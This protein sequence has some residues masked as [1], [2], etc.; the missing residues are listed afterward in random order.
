MRILKVRVQNINS[1]KGNWSVN[2][3][4]PAYSAGGLF[5]ICGPTGAGKSSLLDAIC[6]ALYGSTP[7][8]GELSVNA[9]EAMTRG[10][11]LLES[12]VTFLAKGERYRAL[13]SQRRARNKADGKLQ[14]ATIE[15]CRWNELEAKWEILEAKYKKRFTGLI[16][17]ITGL[18]FEQF[19]RSALLAQ[20]NFSVF[21]KAKDDERSN[22]LEAITGTEIYS[23]ISQAVYN[24]YKGE[25]DKLSAL[26]TAADTANILS[27]DARQELQRKLTNTLNRITQSNLTLS[28]KQ[29]L[30]EK[31]RLIDL[32][33]QTLVKTQKE[34]A[35]V[36][37]NLEELRNERLATDLARR[38]LRIKPQ[39]AAFIQAQ[40]RVA[41]FNQRCAELTATATSARTNFEKINREYLDAKTASDSLQT[42][43]DDLLPILTTV[44]QLDATLV[45]ENKQLTE[46]QAQRARENGFLKQSQ[47]KT[48][49]AA[50]ARQHLLCEKQNLEKAVSPDTASAKLF[51]RQADI[52]SALAHFIESEAQKTQRADTLAVARESLTCIRQ[53]EALAQ[54]SMEPAL[55]AVRAARQA[56]NNNDASRRQIAS[57]D[58]LQTLALAKNKIDARITFLEGLL[59]K[60]AEKDEKSRQLANKTLEINTIQ[61]ALQA[62]EQQL[63]TKEALAQSLQQNIDAQQEL[64]E[65]RSLVERLSLE[66][67]KLSDGTPCPLC[68]SIHHPYVKN[69]PD[70]L[71][72][73]V[74]KTNQLKEKLKQVQIEI[75]RLATERAQLQGTLL[76]AQCTSASLQKD[77]DRLHSDTVALFNQLAISSHNG[78]AVEDALSASQAQANALSSRLKML[79]D[80]DDQRSSL[81][82]E[83]EKALERLE[84]NNTALQSCK[85]QVQ[86]AVTTHAAAQSEYQQALTQLQKAQEMLAAACSGLV[87]PPMDIPSTNA[88]KTRLRKELDLHQRNLDRLSEIQTKLTALDCTLLE[89]RQLQNQ[90]QERITALDDAIAKAQM[91]YFL[92]QSKRIAL[93]GEKNTDAEEHALKCKRNE[94]Q[95]KTELLK[96]RLERQREL[97]DTLTGQLRNVTKQLSEES[98]QLDIAQNC[99]A[100]QRESAGFS[101]DD[102]WLN[103]LI[104][105][106]ELQ[107]RTEKYARLDDRV[108]E[109]TRNL[110]S[111]HSQLES[112]TATTDPDLSVQTVETQMQQ[113]QTELSE[114]MEEKGRLLNTIAND[115][116]Q[117][118]FLAEK[119]EAVKLQED[120]LSIWTKLNEL[121]GSANGKRYRTFVQSMTFETLLH[122]ANRALSKI[123]PR[124]ILKKSS[125][126]ALKLNVIDTFQGGIERSADNLSGGESFLVS[127]SLALG[128]SAMASRNVKVESLF[129][130]EGFGSLDPDTLEEAMN[131]LAALQNEGKMI[132]IISH[133]G[134]I[135]ERIA[136][137]I[138]VIPMSGG[139]SELSG[140]GVERLN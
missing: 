50:Q 17:E 31:L 11:A 65:M 20:G 19:T 78:R 74:Q 127:L 6:I 21:L 1:L 42:A 95:Q 71:S 55:C 120:N 118:Q 53:K 56:L 24:R 135:R 27:E 41:S 96:T 98:Q 91:Q 87:K 132:G 86:E 112:L 51:A 139:R 28:E 12:E 125:S 102:C 113:I 134:E 15:L 14:S 34:L 111:T 8:L 69:K 106:D 67:S 138:D 85:L 80:L 136:T 9:N 93:F 81:N 66:R 115:D 119:L 105:E 32:T 114:M 130:D 101:N 45:Q 79:A 39:H 40:K 100:Q 2:F 57:G 84:A 77:I 121:I 37:Q 62:S 5:A 61:R 126:E 116:V 82:H 23:K 47:D 59:Q 36:E 108:K 90:I 131:A 52:Q 140:P 75:T 13:Y 122:H 103:A 110:D 44:R 29:R 109:L 76:A 54:Q 10:T 124:Y 7:R 22:A 60:L 18:T 89:Q 94:S 70:V 46:K 16:T 123:S 58:N 83:L 30:C 92:R 88:W 99:W 137:I 104:T 128:L 4:D 73:D 72:T 117:R 25:V 133:V 48:Q 35:A 33:A 63:K 26:K 38:A 129:L 107:C 64:D 97:L 49:A 43:F 3:E 68:G